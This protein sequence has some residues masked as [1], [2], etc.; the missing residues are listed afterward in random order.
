MLWF[1]VELKET[2]VPYQDLNTSNVMVS[3]IIFCCSCPN[4]INLNT[5]NVMVSPFRALTRSRIQNYLNT[6]NVMVSHETNKNL[7]GV[8]QFKYIKCYGFTIK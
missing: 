8:P 3:P 4:T 2:E 1:H 7:L 6:S 5:S